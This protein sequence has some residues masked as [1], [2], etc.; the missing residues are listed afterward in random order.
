MIIMSL[1][2]AAVAF[3]IRTIGVALIPAILFAVF[4]P[5]AE[6]DSMQ[7]IKNY[8]TYVSLLFLAGVLGLVLYVLAPYTNYEQIIIRLIQTSI[9]ESNPIEALIL[10]LNWKLSEIAQIVLNIPIS[11]VPNW[12]LPLFLLSGGLVALLLGHGFYAQLKTLRHTD[13]YFAIYA[14]IVLIWHYQDPRFWLPVLP[15]LLL[16]FYHGLKHY[17]H[18]S[19]I[20]LGRK[21]W[22]SLY[23]VMGCIAFIYSTYLTFS[24]EKFAD[25]YGNGA[26]RG[27]YRE[28]FFG[29]PMA[30]KTEIQEQ[31]LAILNW[32]EPRAKNK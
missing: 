25:H 29:T 28:A 24:G 23:I 13:I 30:N 12:L 11:I 14:L 3:W 16:F 15:F 2:L 20:R 19:F 27:I 5:K 1:I 18:V 6:L 9:S 26:Y 17:S 31:Q 7:L 21:T 32:Y 4:V 8:R 10:H 22:I